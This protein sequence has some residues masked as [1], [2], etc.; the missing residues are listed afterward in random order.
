MNFFLDVFL[1]FLLKLHVS[2]YFWWAGTRACPVYLI[3][4][5]LTG[6]GL[7]L[8][9]HGACIKVAILGF[10]A[11]FFTHCITLITHLLPSYITQDGTTTLQFLF[12]S[13]CFLISFLIVLQLRDS[14]LTLLFLETELLASVALSAIIWRCSA[15]IFWFSVF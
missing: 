13:G 6:S 12:M 15:H 3:K 8:L 1:S 4:G 10:V 2:V 5:L 14:L 9:P 7:L 11:S